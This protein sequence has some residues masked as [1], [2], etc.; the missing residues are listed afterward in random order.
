MWSTASVIDF[1]IWL[2]AISKESMFKKLPWLNRQSLLSGSGWPCRKTNAIS[3]KKASRKC[4]IYSNTA[5]TCWPIS[6]KDA[7]DEE[8]SLEFLKNSTFA[9][10]YRTYLEIGHKAQIWSRLRRR[11]DRVSF[12]WAATAISCI[13]FCLHLDLMQDS[14]EFWNQC[15]KVVWPYCRMAIDL[16]DGWK[17]RIRYCEGTRTGTVPGPNVSCEIISL[18]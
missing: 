9:L 17:Q 13:S 1:G 8:H 12:F 18:K 16:H 7:Q 14:R 15:W 11:A 6:A 3:H 5:S 10:D 2:S 4:E